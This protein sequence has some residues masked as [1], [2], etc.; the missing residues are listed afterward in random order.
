M[1]LI[2]IL[3]IAIAC[4]VG[5]TAAVIVGGG[6]YQKMLFDEYMEDIEDPKRQSQ[7]PNPNLPTIDIMP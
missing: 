5:I 6:M 1:R 3:A 4:G 7:I 2:V